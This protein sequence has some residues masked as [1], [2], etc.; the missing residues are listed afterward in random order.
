MRDQN[1]HISNALLWITNRLNQVT[2]GDGKHTWWLAPAVLGA[3][4]VYLAS[5][6]VPLEMLPQ[7][8]YYNLLTDAFLTG[9]LALPVDP[10]PELL[11]LKDPYDPGANG[12]FRLHDVALYNGKYYLYHGLT[13]AVLLFGPAKLFL[14]ITINQSTAVWLFVSAGLIAATWCLFI[15]LRIGTTDRPTWLMLAGIVALGLSNAGPFMLVRPDVYEVAISC[16]YFLNM[17]FLALALLASLSPGTPRGG[18]LVAFAGLCLGLAVGA[19]PNSIVLAPL[20][21]AVAWAHVHSLGHRTLSRG[22]IA[23]LFP[24]LVPFGIC[25]LTIM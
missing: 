21:T 22:F 15:L 12:P 13:P 2:G 16:G 5:I 24:L 8:S 11:A 23:C 10:S 6:T 20:L 1:D 17:T 3:I 14:G 25:I 19:R 4:F 9:T 18:R 7:N